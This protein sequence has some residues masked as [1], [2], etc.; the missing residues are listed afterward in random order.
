L[1][2]NELSYDI[3]DFVNFTALPKDIIDDLLSFD[4]LVKLKVLKFN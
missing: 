1:F 4:R 3:D 2:K